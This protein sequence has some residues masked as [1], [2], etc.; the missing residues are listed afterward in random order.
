MDVL[1][2]LIAV[3][4]SL[5]LTPADHWATVVDDLDQVRAAAFASADPGLLDKV[6][7]PGSA[8]RTVDAALIADYADRGG[9][10][11][12]ARLRAL[13]CRV[14]SETGRTARLDVVDRL[15]DARVMWSDGSSHDLP[16]DR[17]SRRTIILVNTAEGWRIAG[18]SSG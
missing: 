5:G 1:W 14:L 3:F 13:S 11:V 18:V 6:Y 10:V 2:V 9:R 12:G 4:R 7:A 8:A 15:D 17:P 16:R